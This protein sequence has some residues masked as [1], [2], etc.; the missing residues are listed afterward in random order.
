[1]TPGGASGSTGEPAPR[2]D[3]AADRSARERRSYDEGEVFAES[4][5]LHARFEHVFT[6]PNS[7]AAEARFAE[8]V[9][10]H[11]RG[12]RVLSYGCVRVGLLMPAV[13]AAVPRSVL[14]V[15]ISI[16]EL[17]EVR[18]QWGAPT[19]YAVMDGHALASRAGSF[20]LVVGRAIVHHLDVDAALREIHR[21]LA[22]GGVAAFIEPLRG[23]PLLAIGRLL[24][25]RARTA[26]ELPL[27]AAQIRGGDR[28]FGASEHHFFN[29]A[30]VPAGVVSS[31]V[32]TRP[33]NALTR[34]ADRVDRALATTPAKY[35]MRSAVLAWRKTS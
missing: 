18:R 3:G 12:A 4:A 20:D 9:R 8:L 23:N 19:A 13:L 11:A 21:V 34:A 24:T 14:V 10:R 35:W 6:G 7:A 27:S 29:L 5:R 33:D 15:D 25:P 26:D 32:C 31:L 22:P 16:R 1:V 17:D 2:P 30:S 28:L